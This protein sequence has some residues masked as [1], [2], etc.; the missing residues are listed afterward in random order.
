MRGDL[1]AEQRVIARDRVAQELVALRVGAVTAEGFRPAHFRNRFESGFHDAGRERTG[2]VADA[3]L[4]DVGVRVRR[5]I[6]LHAVG[7]FHEQ[8]AVLNLIV[9]GI[10]FHFLLSLR[11]SAAATKALNMGCGRCGRDLNSG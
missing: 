5:G 8:I 9:I 11:L 6:L 4:Y 7:Y 10:D 3:Q 1:D 2:Y